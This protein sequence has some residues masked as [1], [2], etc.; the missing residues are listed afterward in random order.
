MIRIV[1]VEGV[2]KIESVDVA[3]EKRLLLTP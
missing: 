2:R 1:P 3:E